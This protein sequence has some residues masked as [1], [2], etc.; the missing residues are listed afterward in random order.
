MRNGGWI[1]LWAYS[2]PVRGV[3]VSFC[4]HET[5][6]AVVMRAC[7]GKQR[8][9]HLKGNLMSYSQDVQTQC[10]KRLRREVF[11]SLKHLFNVADVK[12]KRGFWMIN[13]V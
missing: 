10:L 7:S 11:S 3:A 5:K 6:D 9:Q 2:R 4:L 8:T 1:V 12:S 13:K